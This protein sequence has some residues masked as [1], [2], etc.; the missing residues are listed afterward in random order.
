M[1]KESAK[2]ELNEKENSAQIL[3]NLDKIIMI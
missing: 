3:K 2:I 1:E